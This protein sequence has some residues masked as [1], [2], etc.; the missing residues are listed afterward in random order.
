MG[1]FWCYDIRM[2]F[3]KSQYCIPKNCGTKIS[4]ESFGRGV[5][6]FSQSFFKKERLFCHVKERYHSK[7]LYNDAC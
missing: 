4:K 1:C 7:C 5:T 3:H 6:Y 2:K